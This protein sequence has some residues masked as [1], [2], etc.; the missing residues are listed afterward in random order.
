M[1]CFSKPVAASLLGFSILA[2]GLSAQGQE[3]ASEPINITTVDG[4]RLRGAFYPGGKK[5]APAV[6]MLH[7]IGEGMNSRS[8][9]WKALAETLQKK[10]GFS[11]ATFDF[12]GHGESTE[13][14]VPEEFWKLPINKFNVKTKDASA[15][16][17]KNFIKSPGYMPILVNDIAAIR[18]YLDRKNDEGACNTSNLLIVGAG[19]GGTLGTIWMNSEWNRYKYI[20]PAMMFA[21]PTIDKRSE[22]NDIIGAVFLTLQPTIGSRSVSVSNI[23][24]KACL[25]QGTAAVFF[26]GKEDKKT[27]DFAKNLEKVIK[28]KKSKKHELIGVSELPTNLTDVKLLKTTGLSD[29]IVDYFKNVVNERT[30]EWL[31]RDFQDTLYVW[32]NPFNQVPFPAKKT[33]GE[34]NMLFDTYEL[35]AK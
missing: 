14:D 28:P 21:K 2:L 10:G 20:P 11:V 17:V 8:Q 29:G 7:P 6:I 13:I 25:E 4:V 23:L 30:N 3:A 18:A 12:R 26:C 1:S 31:R 9:D 22:G 16:D 15:I 33:K 27:R 32:R 35:F 24:R 34:K 5:N 19:S